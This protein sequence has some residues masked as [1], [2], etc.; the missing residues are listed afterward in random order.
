MTVYRLNMTVF[1][2]DV[3]EDVAVEVEAATPDDAVKSLGVRG[4]RVTDNGAT[5]VDPLATDVSGGTVYQQWKVNKVTA[6]K[7]TVTTEAA[8]RRLA[9]MHDQVNAGPD[10]GVT[11]HDA[12]ALLDGMT[13]DQLRD[14]SA[15]GPLPASYLQKTKGDLVQH[16]VRMNVGN[17]LN[18]RAIVGYPELGKA[19]DWV[20]PE[21]K[22]RAARMAGDL[23]SGG[24]PPEKPDATAVK[25]VDPQDGT[26]H[27]GVIKA[28][29][30]TAA[31][32]EWDSGR[33][34][35]GVKFSDPG[36]EFLTPDNAEAARAAG[37]AAQRA[38][39]RDTQRGESDPF[40][41]DADRKRETEARLR[42]A[43]TGALDDGRQTG[44]VS[45]VELRAALPDV[46]REE[47]DAAATNVFQ[48]SDVHPDPLRTEPDNLFAHF[49]NT[50]KEEHEAGLVFGGQNT[51]SVRMDP[52]GRNL[53]SDAQRWRAADRDQ[54]ESYFATCDEPQLRRLADEFGLDT[55]G[56]TDALRERLAD[57]A[58]RNQREDSI[59]GHQRQQ[60]QVALAEAEEALERGYGP[61][62][63]TDAERA[64][65]AAAARRQATDEWDI[66]RQRAALFEDLPE[67]GSLGEKWAQIA[68]DRE[69]TR[70]AKK[71]A[72]DTG[73]VY[74]DHIAEA[75]SACHAGRRHA[76]PCL[77]GGSAPAHTCDLCGGDVGLS[78][79]NGATLCTRCIADRAAYDGGPFE[80]GDG[81]G[82]PPWI[83][84]RCSR[85]RRPMTIMAGT[86]HFDADGSASVG[87]FCPRCKIS[88]GVDWTWST[89]AAPA[90]DE[91]TCEECGRW[92]GHSKHCPLNGQPDGVLRVA[93]A[94]DGVT[95]ELLRE[96]LADDQAGRYVVRDEPHGHVTTGPLEDA[97][98]MNVA[99]DNHVALHNFQHAEQEAK[100]A[101]QPY[102]GTKEILE[103][104]YDEIVARHQALDAKM[105]KGLD[106][107]ADGLMAIEGVRA[108][109]HD[110]ESGTGDLHTAVDALVAALV[111]ANFDAASVAG[112]AEAA[113]ALNPDLVQEMI[114]SVDITGDLIYESV[115]RLEPAQEA[116]EAS[117]EHV[118]ATYGAIAE[119]VQVAGVSG[120]AM[121]VAGA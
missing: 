62:T 71:E 117:K 48:H 80:D 58:A 72:R 99:F 13:S 83:E 43:I 110:M 55:D 38:E 92:P 87:T 37:E 77:S 47:F 103:M 41:G 16:V 27:V 10:H 23:S 50:T 52:Q 42:A 29:N 5:H 86:Q 15:R 96:E 70:E 12:E 81:T 79:V 46:S 19:P 114:D 57:N 78:E 68:K 74:V 119:G 18:H 45:M 34:E 73:Q 102:Q 31:T 85:C 32:V 100:P 60:D 22:E 101:R 54:A 66:G 36:V 7:S 95:I 76:G 82:I 69:E 112:A 14:V 8:A 28:R 40:D 35:K 91:R 105:E 17:A 104:K 9:E 94:D 113:N 121:E 97:D 39:T 2:G 59:R 120:K 106:R 6:T 107:R 33:V 30:K 51:L 111:D 84:Q 65:V 20:G 63:W 64:E 75:T 115:S 21:A 116:V 4:V 25:W 26:V 3:A 109:V 53:T 108:A 90:E 67:D 88:S 44:A 118:T 11:S 24:K 56:D 61:E 89:G 98:R 93:T 49:G 1:N